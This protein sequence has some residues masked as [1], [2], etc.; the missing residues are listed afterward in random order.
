MQLLLIW[1][2]LLK[3]VCHYTFA[4]FGVGVCMSNSAI[5]PEIAIGYARNLQRKFLPYEDTMKIL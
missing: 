2:L 1:S 5:H 4:P 3:N